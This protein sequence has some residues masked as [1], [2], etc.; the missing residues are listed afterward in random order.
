MKIEK[1]YDRIAELDDDPDDPIGDEGREV[2]EQVDEKIIEELLQEVEK[3]YNS[4]R[5]NRP[6]NWKIKDITYSQV[7]AYGGSD[8]A[9]IIVRYNLYNSVVNFANSLRL[10]LDVIDCQ[11]S[12]EWGGS[13]DRDNDYELTKI[14]RKV[15][16]KHFRKQVTPYLKAEKAKKQQELDKMREQLN[17]EFPFDDE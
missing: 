4:R 7:F 16:L 9:T 5:K 13:E 2:M 8:R 10:Y 12:Y 6:V 1:V 15:L 14:W 11:E 17:N 3:Y